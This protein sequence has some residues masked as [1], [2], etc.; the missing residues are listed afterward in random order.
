[1][2]VRIYPTLPE[3]ACYIRETVFVQE[4][5]FTDEFDKLDVVSTHLVLFAEDYPAAVCRVYWDDNLGQYILGRVAVLGEFRRQGI[6]GAMVK[7]AEDYIREQGGRELHLHAQC[8]ITDFYEAIGYTQYGPVEDDQG[9]P[10]IWMKKD[11]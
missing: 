1:M 7:A 3:E 4:Q 5:G 2:Y 11:L 9:C 6:G 10:H 8:R